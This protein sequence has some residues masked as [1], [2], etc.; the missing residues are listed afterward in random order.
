MTSRGDK[1]CPPHDFGQNDDPPAT[2]A[3]MLERRCP[4]C[5]VESVDILGAM[6]RSD[7]K[8]TPPRPGAELESK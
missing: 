2:L 7:A 1:L 4:A 3:E 6:V 8:P 5:G